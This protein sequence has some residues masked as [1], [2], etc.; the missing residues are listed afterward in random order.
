M[1]VAL[2]LEVPF[3]MANTSAMKEHTHHVRATGR[4]FVLAL[5]GE[6]AQACA[7]RSAAAPPHGGG[8]L[9]VHPSP[10]SPEAHALHPVSP[11]LFSYLWGTGLVKQPVTRDE[12]K[13]A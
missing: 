10:S 7:G 4:G 2:P 12:Q 9:R 3:L 13:P 11:E 6:P 8:M 1:A 5:Q